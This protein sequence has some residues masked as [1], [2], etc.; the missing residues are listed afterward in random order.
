[1]NKC[2]CNN[3][4]ATLDINDQCKYEKKDRVVAITLAALPTSFLGIPW[5]Y[6][7]YTTIGYVVLLVNIPI[8][9]AWFLF[10]CT[11]CFCCAN[12]IFILMYCGD[13][14]RKCND[15]FL[16]SHII[17]FILVGSAWFVY[18]VICLGIFIKDDF[19]DGNGIGLKN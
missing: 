16:I 1:M 3:D 18:Y 10:I 8:I 7:D 14:D 6:T 19:T 15:V 13:E 11:M 4:Y 2:I 5:F 12:P 9:L 17:P